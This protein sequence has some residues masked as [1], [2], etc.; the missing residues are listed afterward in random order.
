M[1]MQHHGARCDGDQH[2][3]FVRIGDGDRCVADGHVAVVRMTAVE[4]QADELGNVLRLRPAHDLVDRARLRHATVFED[5][6][7]VGERECVDRV[8][9]DEHARAANV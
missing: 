1:A 7:A 2:L 6:H 3:A 5:Q 8:V 9:G 4:V